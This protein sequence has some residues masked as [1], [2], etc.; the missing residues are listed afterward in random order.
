MIGYVGSKSKDSVRVHWTAAQKK[1][2][3]P[4]Y[5]GKVPTT[6]LVG[7]REH[8]SKARRNSS[9]IKKTSYV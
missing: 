6:S 5:S 7:A 4:F 3:S 2:L 8:S 1:V 9:M